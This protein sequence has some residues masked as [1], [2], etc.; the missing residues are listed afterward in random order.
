MVPDD[1]GIATD[2]AIILIILTVDGVA[3][4][5]DVFKDVNVAAV[6]R[7]LREAKY[8]KLESYLERDKD[9]CDKLAGRAVVEGGELAIEDG[10]EEVLVVLDH[11]EASF[12]VFPEIQ[13]LPDDDGSDPWRECV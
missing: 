1:S 13:E 8:A 11:W 4:I 10:K 3:V 2:L 9:A 6:L 12:E 5:A 7:A